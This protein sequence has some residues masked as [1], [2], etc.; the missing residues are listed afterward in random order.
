[1]QSVWALANPS[2]TPDEV[3]VPRG[4]WILSDAFWLRC[5]YLSIKPFLII[6]YKPSSGKPESCHYVMYLM[7]TVPVLFTYLILVLFL[8]WGVKG[9]RIT[10]REVVASRD[11]I[12]LWF[13]EVLGMMA[14]MFSSHLCSLDGHGDAVRSWKVNGEL[15]PC[16]HN[17][18]LF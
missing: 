2:L 8:V 14:V 3:I 6:F 16:K 11:I 9:K 13:Q 4:I 17:P 12:L 1:M 15:I 5:T 10:L 18:L 7:G